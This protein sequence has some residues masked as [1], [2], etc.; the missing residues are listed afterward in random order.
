[1]EN[2][3]IKSWIYNDGGRSNYFKTTGRDCVTRAV[4]IASGMD[5]LEVFNKITELKWKAGYRKSALHGVHTRSKWFKTQMQKWGWKWKQVKT[6]DHVSL[7]SPKLP[8]SKVIVA[9]QHH[10]VALIDGV[11]N[12]TYNPDQPRQR[13]LRSPYGKRIVMGYWVYEG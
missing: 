4:A 1:M 6:Y 11:I 2:V 9:L 13:G 5:Y 3:K 12:D 10:Y 8:K 7:D